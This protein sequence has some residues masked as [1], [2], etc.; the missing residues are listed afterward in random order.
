M[1]ARGT[2]RS[3]ARAATA[4]IILS[5]A[6]AFPLG[7]A[8]AAVGDITSYPLPTANSGPFAIVAGPDGN[9]WFTEDNVNQVGKM[10]TSGVVTEYPI[11][12]AA[13]RPEGITAGPDGN[14]W[15]TE[16]SANKVAKVTTTGVITEYAAPT[17][18][19]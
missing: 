7:D 5:A 17:G 12:A 19:G 3:P 15:F 8:I 18:G 11:P 2:K 16:A 14:L 6:L 10:T 13:S 1:R 4:L 9:I